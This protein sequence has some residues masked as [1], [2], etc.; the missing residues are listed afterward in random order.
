MEIFDMSA[1]DDVILYSGKGQVPKGE[2]ANPNL[3]YSY[4]SVADTF[5]WGE[6]RRYLPGFQ[7]AKQKKEAQ[8]AAVPR[9]L[10]LICGSEASRKE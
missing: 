9:G 3:R 1:S 5:F 7:S 8:G 4:A 6:K 2:F 10:Q